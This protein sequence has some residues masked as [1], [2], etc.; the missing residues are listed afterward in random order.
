MSTEIMN[1]IGT[2]F[3]EDGK[4]HRKL[5]FKSSRHAKFHLKCILGSL[6]SRSF[7]GRQLLIWELF[8]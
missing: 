7:K 3:A 4:I 5:N 2:S 8:Q 1:F 6:N